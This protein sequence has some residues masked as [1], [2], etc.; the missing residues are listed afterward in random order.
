[1]DAPQTLGAPVPIRIKLLIDS[2]IFLKQKR[3]LSCKGKGAQRSCLIQ[4]LH[5]GRCAH[6]DEGEREGKDASH[7]IAGCKAGTRE[8]GIDRTSLARKHLADAVERVEVSCKL[9]GVVSLRE[10]ASSV[11]SDRSERS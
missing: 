4:L 6:A 7:R 2:H 11:G 8:P 1:M 10:S 3:T 5:V 9:L